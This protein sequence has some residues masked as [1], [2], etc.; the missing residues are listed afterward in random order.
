M[1]RVADE[2]QP[3]AAIDDA[4]GVQLDAAALHE[5]RV[6][7][8]LVER[9]LQRVESVHAH[10]QGDLAHVAR[11]PRALVRLLAEDLG[12]AVDAI[13]AA[14]VEQLPDRAGVEQQLPARRLDLVHLLDAHE[15][16]PLSR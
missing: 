6:D 16:V 8:Q 14:V 10:A 4:A 15:A 9:E 12:E 1:A 13:V 2:Q 5:Q 7:E 11:D 3:V